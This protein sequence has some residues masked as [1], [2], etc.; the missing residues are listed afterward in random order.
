VHA[1]SIPYFSRKKNGDETLLNTEKKLTGS[2]RQRG[3]NLMAGQ[4]DA[5]PDP[6]FNAKNGT[7]NKYRG[8]K[9]GE[10]DN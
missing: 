9:S 6:N 2:Q 1:G 8:R 5:G 7:Y 3:M 4:H 10:S